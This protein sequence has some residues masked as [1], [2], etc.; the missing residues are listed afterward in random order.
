MYTTPTVSV[1]CSSSFSI[2]LG[3]LIILTSIHANWLPSMYT[4]ILSYHHMK[5]ELHLVSLSFGD[6]DSRWWRITY[7]NGTRSFSDGDRTRTCE[8]QT[9]C[10]RNHIRSK[11]HSPRKLSRIDLWFN[12]VRNPFEQSSADHLQGMPHTAHV[13][14]SSV[15]TE[16]KIVMLVG[17]L[18]REGHRARS[19]WTQLTARNCAFSNGSIECCRI[20][21][22]E[23]FTAAHFCPQ[24]ADD[25]ESTGSIWC[26]S[27]L[28]DWSTLK[29]K[30]QKIQTVNFEVL[31]TLWF[32]FITW[33][34]L[35]SHP[36][37]LDHSC[38][39]L[40]RYWQQPIS[41]R[42]TTRTECHVLSAD[43]IEYENRVIPTM[44][45]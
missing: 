28:S 22:L 31:V 45:S 12:S 36:S 4:E 43:S 17:F 6:P 10:N 14:G 19:N 11:F 18:V 41:L 38:W 24:R 5:T 35:Y 15:E 39:S 7:Q 9:E 33:R 3:C 27:V 44:V 1:C 42:G 25:E 20:A 26:G 2:G 32:L 16:Y 29:N 21:P 34:T 37:P 8:F 13:I 30:T 23:R 40:R